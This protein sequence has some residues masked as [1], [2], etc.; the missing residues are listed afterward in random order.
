MND[1][2]MEDGYLHYSIATDSV[3]KKYDGKTLNQYTGTQSNVVIPNEVKQLG[4]KCFF[5]NQDLRKVQLPNGLIDIY[6]KVFMRCE[7]LESI[8]IPSSVEWIGVKA[9]WGC[10]NLKTV[11]I[12]GKNVAFGPSCFDWCSSLE[13]IYFPSPTVFSKVKEQL[14]MAVSYGLIP[15]NV[16]VKYL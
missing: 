16:K 2:I 5:D 8:D 6:D 9:F 13:T 11:I 10:S 14:Q 1:F 4:I 15:N 3:T 12:R 7:N